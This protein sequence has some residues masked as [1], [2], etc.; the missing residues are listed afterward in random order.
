M[1]F[2]VVGAGVVGFVPD[3]GGVTVV[4]CFTGTLSISSSF[5]LFAWCNLRYIPYPI[6]AIHSNKTSNVR[7]PD[8]LLRFSNAANSS[9]RDN[10]AASTARDE[11]LDGALWDTFASTIGVFLGLPL[12]LLTGCWELS[13]TMKYIIEC[14]DHHYVYWQS[15]EMWQICKE[16]WVFFDKKATMSIIIIDLYYAMKCLVIKQ[17]TTSR[18]ENSSYR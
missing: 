14:K 17:Q 6:S 9:S 7:T 3:A 11:A 18:K 15:S 8:L 13:N 16:L 10:A 5:S 2:D 1:L 12:H 4:F